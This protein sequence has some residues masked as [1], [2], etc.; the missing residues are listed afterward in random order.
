M[1]AISMLDPIHEGEVRWKGNRILDSSV[2][3]FRK[4]VCYV[5]QRMPTFDGTV[6]ETLQFPFSFGTWKRQRY[7]EAIV[8]DW[9]R[10]LHRDSPFLD[11][12]AR[13]MSGGESQIV[14]LFLALLAS[15]QVLLLDEPTSAMDEQMAILAENLILDWHREQASRAFLWVSHSQTQLSRVADRQLTMQG[16]RLGLR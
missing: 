5:P 11:K 10:M 2:P 3:G 13:D 6:R 16:G 7:D 4:A 14:R 15:P 1:R 12:T 8:V 9:L